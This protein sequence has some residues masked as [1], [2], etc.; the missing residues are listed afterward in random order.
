MLIFSL[1]LFLS[2]YLSPLLKYSPSHNYGYLRKKGEWQ[3]ARRTKIH[4]GKVLKWASV[5]C[6]VSWKSSVPYSFSVT[7]LLHYTGYYDI[8]HSILQWQLLTESCSFSFL[9][10]DG[11]CR[12]NTHK[13]NSLLLINVIWDV[14]H[15]LIWCSYVL[16][17]TACRKIEQYRWPWII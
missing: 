11:S 14:Q 9:I 17:K 12:P 4:R 6:A 8:L 16:S 10:C 7:S 3:P 2:L 1:F 5:G 15:L 13:L